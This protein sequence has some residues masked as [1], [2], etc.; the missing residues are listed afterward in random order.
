MILIEGI[1]A[2]EDN[3]AEG[4][5]LTNMDLLGSFEVWTPGEVDAG[6]SPQIGIDGTYRLFTL[7][8]HLWSA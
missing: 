2:R 6:V 7:L 5:Y 8:M 4:Q 3:C 1:S